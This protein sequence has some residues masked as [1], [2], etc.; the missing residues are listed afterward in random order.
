MDSAE[1]HMRPNGPD[2]DLA[3]RFAGLRA[4]PAATGGNQLPPLRGLADL[5]IDGAANGL[6]AGRMAC[7]VFPA[8]C[9]RCRSLAGDEGARS[10][11]PSKSARTV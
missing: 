6:P 7:A 9:A 11:A 10:P 2:L 5:A 4:D 8:R 3:V 1:F